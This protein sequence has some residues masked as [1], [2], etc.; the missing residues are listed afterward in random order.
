[1]IMTY[2]DCLCN[3]LIVCDSRTK[4][5]KFNRRSTVIGIYLIIIITK[6]IIRASTKVEI[7]KAIKSAKSE[8]A[9]GPGGIYESRP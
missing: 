5:F 8:K 7:I 2:V 3:C 6:Y 9:A 4:L 1:M